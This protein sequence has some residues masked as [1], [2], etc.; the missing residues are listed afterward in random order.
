MNVFDGNIQAGRLTLSG[1]A[2][3]DID[4]PYEGAVKAGIRP[5]HLQVVEHGPMAIDVSYAEPLGATTLL[6]GTMSGSNTAMVFSVPGVYHM[7]SQA[8]QDNQALDRSDR[9]YVQPQHMHLF[10]SETGRRIN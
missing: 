5:E 7:K 8:Y 2:D 6:H 9:V 3:F 10:N 4:T 1:E